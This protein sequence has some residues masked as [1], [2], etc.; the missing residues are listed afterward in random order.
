V[1]LSE[2][3]AYSEMPWGWSIPSFCSMLCSS[4]SLSALEEGMAWVLLV[5]ATHPLS[6][7]M[8]PEASVNSRSYDQ[9]KTRIGYWVSHLQPEH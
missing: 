9:G 1:E 8:P 6:L 3:V 7:W 5:I 2:S 4:S